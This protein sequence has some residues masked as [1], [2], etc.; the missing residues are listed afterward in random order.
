MSAAVFEIDQ[1]GQQSVIGRIAKHGIRIDVIRVIGLSNLASKFADF[2]FHVH[3][4]IVP[5]S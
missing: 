4:K 2:G 1:L 3:M 5:G